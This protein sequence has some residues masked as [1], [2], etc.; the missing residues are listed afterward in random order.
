MYEN[1]RKKAETGIEKNPGF[2]VVYANRA[3][4][5]GLIRINL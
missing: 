1:R 5:C 2:C 3:Y 4:V